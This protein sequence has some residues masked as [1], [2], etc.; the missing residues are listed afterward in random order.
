MNIIFVTAGMSGG[1]TE[2]VISILA[3]KWVVEGH[4]IT[5]VATA[6][7]DVAYK[8]DRRIQLLRLGGRTHGSFLRR[9]KRISQLRSIFRRESD[10]VI[11]SMGIETNMYAVLA[12]TG[13]KNRLLISERNDP[14][15]CTYC[16]I[17]DWFYRGADKLVCQTYEAQDY[18]LG[19]GMKMD[20]LCVIPNPLDSQ[21]PAA[22]AGSRRKAIAAA[23]RLTEQKN[24]KLLI[25]AFARFHRK[26]PEYILEIYGKGELRED[27][28]KQIAGLGMQESVFLMGFSDKLLSKI[29]D[30]SMYVL[31]SDYEGVSNSLMEA[32][33][34]G[35]PVVATDCP[36]GGSSMCI[37]NGVNGLLVPINNEQALVDAM[38][39]LAKNSGK[40]SQMS[41]EA[42]Y[43]RERFSVDRI[44][45]LW[46]ENMTV[47]AIRP[48]LRI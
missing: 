43:I 21:I 47:D 48:N 7:R 34:V 29:Q 22:Y 37:E 39:T 4:A 20:K 35:L 17:R 23:G 44:S 11:C 27:L 28:S 18:F 32:M 45:E 2:R 15:Q 13:L 41:K 5:I 3:N 14:G 30:C 6:N 10:A 38:E 31:C 16:K 26:Y 40:S 9:I 42:V 24:H 33:A 46:M 12:A 8:L 1:G 36:I 19:R 25:N